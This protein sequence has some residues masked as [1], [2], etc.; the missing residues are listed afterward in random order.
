M[1]C[2]KINRYESGARVI[3]RDVV[4]GTAHCVIDVQDLPAG[5]LFY[6]SSNGGGED[7]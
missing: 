6:H 1:Q 5:E 3:G 2:K 4:P 7:G